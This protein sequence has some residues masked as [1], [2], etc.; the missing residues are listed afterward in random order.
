VT[1]RTLAKRLQ[2]LEVRFEPPKDPKFIQLLFV[3]PGGEITGEKLIK[4][5]GPD[6]RG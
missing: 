1:A 6:R 3:A 2:R 5:G 4:V